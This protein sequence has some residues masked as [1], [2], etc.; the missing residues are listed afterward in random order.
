MKIKDY[1]FAVE[2]R[3]ATVIAV[4]LVAIIIKIH[5]SRVFGKKRKYH[6]VAGT[7]I[8]QLFN[9]HRLFDY[10][11]NLITSER[12][13]YKLLGF[14][15]SEVYTANPVNIEYILT[16]NFANYGKGWHHHSI[17]SG[18]IGDG[19]FAV[20]G[21]MWRVQKKAA[22][23]QFSTK[24]LREFSSSV[25]K[26]NAVQLADVVSE[27]AISNNIIE[28][29]DLFIKSTLD[30]VCKV[31][32]GVELDTMCGAY[33]E[34]TE[35]SNAF[36]EASA[37]I[38]FRYVNPL[39]RIKRF[40][41]IG[42]EVVLRNSVRVIDEFVYKLIGSKIEQTQKLQDNSPVMKGDMLSR[43]IELK[44]TDPK[45]LRDISLSF[46]L[47][48]R[49]TTSVTLS[50]FLY[51]LCMHPH[52]QDKVA[53]EIRE[54][55]NVA[56]GSTID[57]VAARVTEENLE[58]MQYL[59]AALNETI[60]LHP[61]VPVVGKC[62]FSDDTWPDGYSVRK[63]DLV[64]FQPYAMGRMKF[65]WGDDAEKFRPERWLDENGVLKKESPFKFTAFQAGPRICLGKEFAYKQMKI[66]SAIL[67]G[68]HN[69]KLADPKKSLKYKITLTLQIDGGLHVYASKRE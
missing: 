33:K 62:C 60:R 5:G 9:V 45:Y 46:I 6:P 26:S 8:H 38:M 51:Q 65:L 61:A 3:F 18:F 40:F 28:M 2:P 15:K 59:H 1:L 68:S 7:V 11:T 55:T 49:D 52:V 23:Y 58:K 42:S 25:F 43:F 48:G 13:T 12:K 31:I 20:D 22:S 4:I 41:N 21:E 64:A 24:M 16:T 14:I 57:E 47:A 34:G 35:F 32:L 10:M 29:Q 63:G 17:L 37:A 66:Y 56:A 67:I 39:W 19:I 36:D 30:S 69:F 53:R 54:A 27:A 50:W 44:E